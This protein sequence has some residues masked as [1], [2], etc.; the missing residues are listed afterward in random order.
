MTRPSLPRDRR[1]RSRSSTCARRT[2]GSRPS[3]AWTSPSQPGTVHAV[4][5]ENGAGKSTLMKILAGAVQPDGGE[6]RVDGEAVRFASPADARRRRHRH[7]LPGAQPLPGALDP[8][9]PVPRRP[10]D[11]LRPRRPRRRCAGGRAPSWRG[12]A[13]T[14]TRTRS[15][16]TSASA[17]A[18]WWSSAALLIERPGVLILDEPNSALN[19]RETQRL[20]TIL[21]ELSAGGDDDPLRLPPARGGL[22][23]RRPHHGHAQRRARARPRTARR[24]RCRDVVEAMVGTSPAEL[25]PERPSRRRAASAGAGGG[26]GGTRSIVVE[27]LT[28]GDE[29]RDVDVRGPARRDRRPGRP[30]GLGRR[31]AARRPVRDA[32]ADGRRRSASPTAGARRRP[33]PRPPGAASASC[34]PTAGTRA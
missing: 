29:L 16:A 30:R 5:G 11:P 27:G 13:S 14:S 19:E 33:R 23:D 31:D 25:F 26:D 8:G 12:S 32:P 4:V 15:S 2:A 10:A 3:R 22:R 21:R 17:S 6:V 18:S 7:R 20:F 9:Q 28:V 1:R 24:P 34:P